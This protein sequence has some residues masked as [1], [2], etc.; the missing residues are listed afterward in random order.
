MIITTLRTLNTYMVL[1][2]ISDVLSAH[3]LTAS[4]IIGVLGM[5]VEKKQLG[6]EL[7]KMQ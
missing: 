4:R 3:V 7:S 6:R 5:L 1:I 2:H